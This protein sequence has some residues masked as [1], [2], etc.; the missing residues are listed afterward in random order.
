VKISVLLFLLFHICAGIVIPT[1]DI[2]QDNSIEES[3]VYINSERDIETEEEELDKNIEFFYHSDKDSS[4][5]NISLSTFWKQDLY[6]DIFLN[7]FVT[8]PETNT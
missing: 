4:K 3:I 8:P 5:L 1:I 6:Q 2:L 7:R